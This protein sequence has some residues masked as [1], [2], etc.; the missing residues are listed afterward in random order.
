MTQPTLT[1]YHFP[2][3]CSQ[4][5]LCALETAG[6]DYDLRLV[7]LSRGGQ[8][9]PDYQAM[10]PLGKVPLLLIDG[11]PL[12]ENVALLTYIDALRPDAGV[13]PADPSPLARAEVAGGLAFCAGTLHP[14]VRGIA[15]PMRMTTGDVEG[16]REKSLELSAKSFAYAEQRLSER[17]WW[18]ETGS[19]IDVYLDWAFSVAA[20]GAFDTAPYP[21]LAR[22][23][24]RLRER[25]GYRG[26]VARNAAARAELAL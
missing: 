25:P 5:T 21:E 10:S 4:V 12:A 9:A 2:G 22:L 1:L 8:A 17:G 3:A 24:E 15:N 7:D 18:L 11:V 20:R 19:I 26:M 13:L 16:V 6:L 23:P 14:Q